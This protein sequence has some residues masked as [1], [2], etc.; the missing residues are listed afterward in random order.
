MATASKRVAVPAMRGK[1]H[2]ANR[3]RAGSRVIIAGVTPL[4]ESAL[5]PGGAAGAP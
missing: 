1:S 2:A 4:V 3:F 5:L